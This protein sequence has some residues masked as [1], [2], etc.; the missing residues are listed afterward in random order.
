MAAR[1]AFARAANDDARVLLRWGGQGAR[2]AVLARGG[3]NEAEVAPAEVPQLEPDAGEPMP[4]GP[5]LPSC[6]CGRSP[7]R[8]PLG[9]GEAMVFPQPGAVTSRARERRKN[10][11]HL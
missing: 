3:Q 1:E 11:K 10:S 7:N 5:D 9:I 8:M 2:T 6:S 4:E